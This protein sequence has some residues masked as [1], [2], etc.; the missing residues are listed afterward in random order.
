MGFF[1]SL[2]TSVKKIAGPLIGTLLGVKAAA[3]RVIAPVG[4][5]LQ[6]QLAIPQPVLRTA[7][8]RA[9]NL[10]RGAGG[11]ALATGAG[12]GISALAAGAGQ[13]ADGRVVV[14]GAAGRGN[15]QF[16]KQTLVQ[17]IDVETGAIVRTVVRSGAP[18]LMN[19]EVRQLRTVARK[20]GRAH[21]KLP[22]VTRAPSLAKQLQDKALRNAL[23]AQDGKCS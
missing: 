20:L 23:D 3:P 19:R 13:D 1:T 5:T 15:G 14:E 4:R 10:A 12:V 9:A 8:T 16:V 22:R 18:F 2:I 17:T 6:Q 7:A 21:A 11:L